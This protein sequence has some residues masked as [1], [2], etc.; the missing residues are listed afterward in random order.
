MSAF[1][2]C[3]LDLFFICN[4]LLSAYLSS[5]LHLEGQPHVVEG[6][7]LQDVCHPDPHLEVLGACQGETECSLLAL[8]GL[9]R[10]EGLQGDGLV[11]ADGAL[12]GLQVLEVPHLPLFGRETRHF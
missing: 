6:L 7:L 5:E 4:I 9:D 11:L 10:Q 3:M 1:L 12:H 2:V 8:R